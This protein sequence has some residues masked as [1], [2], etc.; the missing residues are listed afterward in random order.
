[1]FWHATE[2]EILLTV[3]E[4]AKGSLEPSNLGNSILWDIWWPS[5]P[6]SVTA[7]VG[8]SVTLVSWRVGYH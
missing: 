4:L 7:V 5:A 2:V 8:G 6:W 1:V 3:S